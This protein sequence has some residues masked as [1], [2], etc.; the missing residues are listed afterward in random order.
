VTS[1]KT[2][3]NIKFMQLYPAVAGDTLLEIGTAVISA[4][5]SLNEHLSHTNTTC[6][7]KL[8]Y[9]LLYCCFI[10]Y[11]PVRI[12][13]AKCFMNSSKQFS[14]KVMF[15]NEHTFYS[16]YAVFV[17]AQFFAQLV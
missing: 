6:V 1:R 11:F 14:C 12:C 9:Q 5:L 17:P 4:V 13:I 3:G 16:E 7:L 10:Q 15:E 2:N 8:F